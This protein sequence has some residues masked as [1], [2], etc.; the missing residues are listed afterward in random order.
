MEHCIA[1]YTKQVHLYSQPTTHPGQDLMRSDAVVSKATY[2][3][4]TV[5]LRE[6]Q[7]P[8]CIMHIHVI[9]PEFKGINTVM[10]LHS[11]E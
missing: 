10:Q 6:G 11:E 2:Y 9:T 5:G 1:W 3:A 8:L 4:H 7:R